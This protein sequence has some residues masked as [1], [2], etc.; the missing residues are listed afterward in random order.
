M[1]NVERLYEP[2]DLENEV[3]NWLGGEDPSTCEYTTA[4]GNLERLHKLAKDNDLKAKLMPSSETIANGV[5]YLLGLMAVLNYE[6]THV[7]ASKAFSMLKFRKSNCS[8]S[9]TLKP[10]IIDFFATVYFTRRI[11]RT[12]HPFWKDQSCSTQL[13]PSST[14]S[15]F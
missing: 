8:K 7:L 5:V 9:I 2:E 15:P 13:S 10:R 3:L 4:V 12:I 6:Q 11:M 1:S 14:D